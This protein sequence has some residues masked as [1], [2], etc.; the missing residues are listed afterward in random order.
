MEIQPVSFGNKKIYQRT[1]KTSYGKCIEG[2]TDKHEYF[3]YVAENPITK[4]VKHKLYVVNKLIGNGGKERWI[5]SFLRFFKEDANNGVVKE[6]RSQA[7]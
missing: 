3:V 1:I 5:K 2:S 7:K 4:M 6:L